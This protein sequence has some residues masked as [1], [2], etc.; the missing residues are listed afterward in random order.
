MYKVQMHSFD[1]VSSSRI[2]CLINM[3][4]L[5]GL[6]TLFLLIFSSTLAKAERKAA[7]VTIECPMGPDNS[8]TWDYII[9]ATLTF[10]YPN[11]MNKAKFCI[12]CRDYYPNEKVTLKC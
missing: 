2:S 1:P 10:S 12:L 11:Q 4:G 6:R 7:N 3:E 8:I 9:L 5:A